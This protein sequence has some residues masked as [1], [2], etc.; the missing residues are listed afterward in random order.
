LLIGSEGTLG[1]ITEAT[2][3]VTR[4]PGPLLGLLIFFEDTAGVLRTVEA[5]R[6]AKRAG[7]LDCSPL[8]VEYFDAQSLA[9]IR[10]RVAGIPDSARAGLYLE[11]PHAGEAPIEQ[12]MERVMSW[13]ALAEHTLVASD[14]SR[15]EQV[16]AARHAV[17]AAINEQ[18]VRAGQRKIATDFAVPDHA[19]GEMLER[20]DAQQLAHATF[21]HIGDNH[22]HC[23]FL[24]KTDEEAALARAAY[25]RLAEH[26]VA[27][28]GTVSAEH[29][30][31]K[32]KKASLA[33]M[34][35]EAVLADFRTLKRAADPAWILGRGNVL[36]PE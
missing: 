29:G 1:L 32:L 21:G 3:R 23:N 27:L 13:T 15:Q 10:D 9:L 4:R 24:P 30:I 31:G 19:L 8:C 7:Q 5:V 25:A 26:A 28:G 11:Q 34:V 16:H 17:P 22:L 20:Y 2:V 35:P 6:H 33:L 14:R 36:D 12:W 18:L